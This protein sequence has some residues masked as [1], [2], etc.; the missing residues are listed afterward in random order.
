MITKEDIAEGIYLGIS[1][2]RK[3]VLKAIIF[4]LGMAILILI[5]FLGVGKY[6]EYFSCGGWNC[7]S[8]IPTTSQ[9]QCNYPLVY[10]WAYDNFNSNG[11]MV[12]YKEVCGYEEAEIMKKFW[13]EQLEMVEGYKNIQII[14]K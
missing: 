6:Q 12:G 7:Y 11:T 2:E 5:I 3:E 4:S 14:C 10:C 13:E 9:V 8:N 1:R